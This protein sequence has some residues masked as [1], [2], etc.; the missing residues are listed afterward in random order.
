MAIAT[1][2][3][4]LAALLHCT[5]SSCPLAR[6]SKHF[7]GYTIVAASFSMQ[8][9]C[10]GAM[11]CYGVFFSYLQADFGWSR[12]FLS[13]ASSV[14]MLTLGALGMVG[15]RLND[16][17]G[18]R[19]ILLAS[20]LCLSGGYLLMSMLHA[21]WQL[22][23]FYG[24]MVGVGMSTHDVV[25]LSTVARWFKRRRGFMSGLVK[26]GTGTGQFVLPLMASALILTVG[27]R[28]TYVVIGLLILAV[29]LV[30]AN[31]M[32][33]SPEESGLNPDGVTAAGA[34]Q[35]AG[36]AGVSFGEALKMPQLWLCGVSYF[37]VIFGAITILV[38]IVPH[39]TDLGLAGPSAAAVMSTIGASSVVGRITMGTTCDRI[40][41]RRALLTCY[42]IFISALLWLQVASTAWMLFLFAV[43]Y[44]FAHGGLYTALSPTLAELFGLKAHGAVF[45]LVYFWGT[46]GGAIGPVVAGRMFDVQQTYSNAFWL[47]AGLATSRPAAHAAGSPRNRFTHVRGRLPPPRRPS[48]SE[49]MTMRPMAPRCVQW[50]DGHPVLV[51]KFARPCVIITRYGYL[52]ETHSADFR[53]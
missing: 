52:T 24:L 53:R 46:I 16:R 11:A 18:P 49:G 15:G 37:C 29:Y 25:T 5:P 3:R 47:L 38:H 51:F 32:R 10:V 14:L 44:G 34:A 40:G 27:W 2:V 36:A 9:V 30:A 39:A 48:Y 23:V 42:V 45:G 28:N 43:V 50:I 41:S 20:G 8:A 21:G 6:S 4:K 35:V 19:G 26:A 33:R 13:G 1:T 31:L 22:Y 17:F 12:T 7:Y